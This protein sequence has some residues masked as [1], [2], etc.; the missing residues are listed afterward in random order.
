MIS[1]KTEKEIQVMAEG[2]KILAGVVWKV[3]ENAK[4]GVSEVELDK[5]A[6]KLILEKGGYPGFKKVNGYKNAIC[7]STNE[8]VVHGIP[9]AY[10]LKEGDVI[11]IDCGVYY[12]GLH[13]D[14]SETICV[15]AKG[16]SASGGQS[17]ETDKFLETGK[18]A[19]NEA[20]KVAK[21][22]NRVGHI[23]K[24]I[25]D[26]VEGA[27]YSVVQSL[28]GHGVGKNLHE[29]PEVPGFLSLPIEETPILKKG[30]TIAVEVIYN[31]GGHEV[32]L[33]SD[34]WTI[35][36]EDKSISGVFERSIAITDKDPLIL[37]Q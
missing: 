13:T 34:N 15:S 27:G 6:E 22:G 36:T 31:M 12:K 26:V 21:A 24:T 19:L 3:L 8:V 10:K 20:I 5:L 18:K 9:T 14:M 17:L 35:I 2:G 1:I 7:I 29:E 37:T 28:V 25:Q 23:S 30:M 11:G 4:P 33:G 32:V 16:G